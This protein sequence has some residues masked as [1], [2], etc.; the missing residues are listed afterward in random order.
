MFLPFLY[1]E[2]AGLVR[3]ANLQLLSDKVIHLANGRA[4]GQA[5]APAAPPADP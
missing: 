4:M 2:A 5:D 1:D 3:E